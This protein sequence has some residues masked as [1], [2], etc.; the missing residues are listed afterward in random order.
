MG[1]MAEVVDRQTDSD[2]SNERW[3]PC[4]EFEMKLLRHPQGSR[5]ENVSIAARWMCW[6]VSCCIC[7]ESLSEIDERQ[8]VPVVNFP[9]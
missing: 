1:G 2:H 3:N 7:F 5:K 6:I 9:F 8:L 4:S